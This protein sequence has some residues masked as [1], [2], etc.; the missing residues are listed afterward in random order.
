MMNQK[1]K[2]SIISLI[3]LLVSFMCTEQVNA[4]NYINYFG[5]EMTNQEYNTLINLGFTEDEI[6]YQ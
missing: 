1:I 6:Y 4:A 3:V 5:I 2:T